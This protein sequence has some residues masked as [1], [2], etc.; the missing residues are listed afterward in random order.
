MLNFYKNVCI[1]RLGI[2][3]ILFHMQEQGTKNST[4]IPT[5]KQHK[6]TQDKNICLTKKKYGGNVC[7]L[8]CRRRHIAAIAVLEDGLPRENDIAALLQR[9]AD[10]HGRWTSWKIFEH[11]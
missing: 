4:T 3:K 2:S 9:L 6:T 11:L 10:G 5:K 7:L 1:E 8:D